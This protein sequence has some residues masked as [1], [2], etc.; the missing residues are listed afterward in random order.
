MD[1][2]ELFL[3]TDSNDEDQMDFFRT[4]ALCQHVNENKRVVDILTQYPDFKWAENV[5]LE[6]IEEQESGIC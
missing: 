3:T 5:L 1:Y 2:F 4:F 6:I